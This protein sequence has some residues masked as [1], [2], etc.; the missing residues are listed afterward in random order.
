MTSRVSDGRRQLLSGKD[1]AG[2]IDCA[3]HRT[4]KNRQSPAF[5]I[6]NMRRLISDDFVT[7]PTVNRN[8]NLI[9]HCTGWQKDRVFL[10]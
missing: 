4:G 8:R 6:H 3:R 10:T 5:R 9:T 1:A 2:A 7:R